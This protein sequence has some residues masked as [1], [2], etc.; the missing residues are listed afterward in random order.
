MSLKLRS[1]RPEE[2]PAI[3]L[4]TVNEP[5]FWHTPRELMSWD[6]FTS[7]PIQWFVVDEDDKEAV[8]AISLGHIDYI[9][10]C[11]CVG[12][13]VPP[14][15]RKRGIASECDTLIKDFA[16]NKLG[17]HKIWASILSVNAVVVEGMKKRGWK[18]HGT[19]QDAQ[20]L[21]GKWHNRI[22]LEFINPN[23][24]K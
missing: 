15:E 9:N 2:L 8:A 3:H 5:Y 16:F 22:H 23:E 6:A 24:V 21:D 11:A 7:C 18:H 13:V 19:M 12:I 17:L 20:F 1:A 10:R 4:L 14:S